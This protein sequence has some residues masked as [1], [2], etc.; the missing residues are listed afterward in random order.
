MYMKM[1]RRAKSQQE[2]NTE[3]ATEVVKGT[4]RRII[5]VKAPD[6]RVFEEAIFIVRED[7]MR[8]PGV[9]QSKLMEE[10]RQAANGYIGRMRNRAEKKPLNPKLVAAASALG[11]SGIAVAV[12][13]I[14]GM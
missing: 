9:T 13:R 4:A 8:S 2:I 14:I 6:P 11:G 7:Y 10:A 5:V 12:M 3:E 1:E